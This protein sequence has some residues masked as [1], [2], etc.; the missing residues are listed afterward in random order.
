MKRN[1]SRNVNTATDVNTERDVERMSK[2]LQEAN[3]NYT[4]NQFNL[5]AYWRHLAKAAIIEA[6]VGAPDG[7]ATA[8]E[9]GAPAAR[10]Q[11]SVTHC[12]VCRGCEGT[13]QGRG[14]I[15]SDCCGARLRALTAIYGAERAPEA[16]GRS[17]S[18]E[19]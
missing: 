9:P 17:D 12:C 1:R 2:A 13:H 10:E 11:A 8:E 16:S 19:T 4:G 6:G 3:R 7:A 14:T 5:W 15:C 18:G